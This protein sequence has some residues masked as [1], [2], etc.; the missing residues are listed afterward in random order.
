MGCTIYFHSSKRYSTTQFAPT[1]SWDVSSFC[2]LHQP[3]LIR[4]VL[5][6]KVAGR[7]MGAAAVGVRGMALAGT[8]T[9][10]NMSFAKFAGVRLT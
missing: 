8:G 6:G 5:P 2:G 9:G 1:S 4:V 10:A 3:V 7:A